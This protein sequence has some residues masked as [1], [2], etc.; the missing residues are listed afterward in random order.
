MAKKKLKIYK[1]WWFYL[2]LII[3]II[4]ILMIA[5]EGFQRTTIYGIGQVSCTIKGD[6]WIN[7]GGFLY[8]ASDTSDGGNSCNSHEQCETGCLPKN[9]Q[10]GSTT[11]NCNPVKPGYA[12]SYW[13]WVNGTAKGTGLVY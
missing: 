13:L 11:G 1:K 12:S 8:C 6:K 10:E 5:N 2:I 3:P 4:F 7:A 9:G